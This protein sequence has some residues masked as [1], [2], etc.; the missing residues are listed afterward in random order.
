MQRKA[1]NAVSPALLFDIEG[2]VM[3]VNVKRVL[4]RLLLFGLLGLLIEVLFTSLGGLQRGRWNMVGH[5]S[6]WMVIDYCLFAVI[7]MPV[8]RPMARI[9]IPL[10]VRAI[11]YMTFIFVV[12]LVSGWV[13]D[14]CG[15]HIWDYSHLPLNVHGYITLAYAPFWY[16]LGLIAEALY[17]RIDTAALAWALGLSAEHIEALPSGKPAI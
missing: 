13:F 8:G 11:V 6:P 12:E 1:G 14:M 17:R 10:P 5:T 7:L 4:W 9:G 16:G 15:I 2:G 3:P